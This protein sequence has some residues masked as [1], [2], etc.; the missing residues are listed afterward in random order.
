MPGYICSRASP[1]AQVAQL[2]LEVRSLRVLVAAAEEAQRPR[3]GVRMAFAWVTALA[4][5]LLTGLL[6]VAAL[7]G[8]P[9]P[10]TLH[11]HTAG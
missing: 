3:G 8:G 6:I 7:P 10:S 9:D 5:V 4:G 2:Q 1:A 11:P